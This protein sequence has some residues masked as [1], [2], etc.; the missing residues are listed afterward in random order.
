[1]SRLDISVQPDSDGFAID[2]GVGC[3]VASR[4][5]YYQGLA[6][7][8]RRWCLEID[9]DV[10]LVVFDFDFHRFVRSLTTVKQHLKHRYRHANGQPPDPWDCQK[11]TRR[12][13]LGA[14]AISSLSPTPRTNAT[15]P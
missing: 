15:H 13:L 3:S 14:G 4:A 11:R 6:G 5:G 9:L 10:E 1:M 12:P 2:H 7:R 8:R